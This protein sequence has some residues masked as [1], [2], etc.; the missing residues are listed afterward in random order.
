MRKIVLTKTAEKRLTE[1]LAYLESAWSRK[2]KN[3]FTNQLVKRLNFVRENPK[4]F[5]SSSVKQGI[6]KCVIT[7]QI[8]VYYT[9]DDQFIYVLTVFD[10]RQDP[11]SLVEEIK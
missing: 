9:F 5:P 8:T 10:N 11:R 6:H 7:K 2:V 3:Q 1:L 4:A